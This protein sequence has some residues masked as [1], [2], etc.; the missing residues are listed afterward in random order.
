MSTDED[1]VIEMRAKAPP[2]FPW[3]GRELLQLLEAVVSERAAFA[4]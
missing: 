3:K 2:S 4:D 1:Y